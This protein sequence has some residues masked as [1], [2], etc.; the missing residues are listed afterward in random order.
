MIEFD[1]RIE[2][3]TEKRQR[4][5][6]SLARDFRHSPEVGRKADL[7]LG[8]CLGKAIELVVKQQISLRPAQQPVNGGIEM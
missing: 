5:I 2:D 4:A 7:R 8:T 3:R 6:M 1:D